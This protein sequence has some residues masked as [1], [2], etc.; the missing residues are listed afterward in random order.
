M[1]T[2]KQRRPFAVSDAPVTPQPLSF[3]Q[4]FVVEL[5]HVI[6][7]QQDAVEH[8]GGAEQVEQVGS[9]PAPAWSRSHGA[10]SA[11]RRAP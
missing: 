3:M 7:H 1:T 5:M 2:M 9:P 11:A 6:E 8:Q 4:S 10:A